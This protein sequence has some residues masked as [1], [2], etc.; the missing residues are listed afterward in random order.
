MVGSF[1]PPRTINQLSE[2]M[3]PYVSQFNFQPE[4]H[5]TVK[6]MIP[7]WHILVCDLSLLFPGLYVEYIAGN[8][9]NLF[10]KLINP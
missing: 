2:S 5:F 7:I 1:L 4:D 10:V 8:C 9:F 3:A 6:Q